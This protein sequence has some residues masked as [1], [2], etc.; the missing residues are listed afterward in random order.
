MSTD[1]VDETRAAQIETEGRTRFGD[2]WPR[3][4][5]AISK[6]P[7]LNQ[8]ALL[9][10]MKQGNAVDLLAA[11]GRDSLIN[12]ASDGDRQADT[13]YSELRTRERE[14]FRRLRGR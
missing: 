1:L 8:A 14:K 10:V 11:A 12:Q 2:D 4:L 3:L 5:G 7:G 9:E 13:T 6:T